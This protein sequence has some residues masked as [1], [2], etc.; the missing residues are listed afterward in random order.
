MRGPYS[1]FGGTGVTSGNSEATNCRGDG[2]ATLR[3]LLGTDT[4]RQSDDHWFRIKS[5]IDDKDLKWQLDFVELV[6]KASIVDNTQYLEDW[7]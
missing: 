2:V 7:Y 5:V 3:L 4:Y 6:P 1:F